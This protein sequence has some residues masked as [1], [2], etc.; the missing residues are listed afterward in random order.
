VRRRQLLVALGGLGAS[1]AAL[2]AWATN[3]GAKLPLEGELAR[4]AVGLAFVLAALLADLQVANSG[5][6]TLMGAVGLT[7]FLWDLSW[8]YLPVPYTVGLAL[9]ALFQP[10]LAHLTVAFPTGRLRSRLD[11][12]LVRVAYSAWM[13]LS[14]AT[15]VVWDPQV[16]CPGGCSANVL[17]LYPDRAL[18]DGLE[19]IGTV[20]GLTITA[21]VVGAVVRHWRTGSPP[22]RRALAP[23]LWSAVPMAG[24]LTAYTL[25]G[26]AQLPPIAPLV[27][28][29][30]PIA[31]LLGL[32]RMRLTRAGV[33]RLVIELG[34]Q[35]P[36]GRLRDALATALRDSALQVVYWNRERCTF[37][38]VDGSAVDLPAPGSHQQATILEGESGPLAA[39]VHDA[40]LQEDPEL[41]RAVA[42]AARLAIENER[43]QAEIRAQ[44]AEV[45]ASRK[46]LVEAGDTARRR[47]ERD[48]HDGSQ[49]H[50]VTLAAQLG[51]AQARLGNHPDPELANLIAEAVA[52][53]HAA[54]AELRQ[55]ARGL[56]PALLSQAGLGPALQA[57]AERSPLPVTIL[58]S[59]PRRLP[60]PVESTAYFV[61][62]ESLANAAKYARATT[63][64]V[65]AEQTDGHVRVEVVD[66]GVGG[67]DARSG[68][69][70]QG[71]ADR[72]GA[73]DGQ[74]EIA[75]PAGGGTRVTAVIP[76]RG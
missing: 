76:C 65:C 63:V 20:V 24:I 33:G 27:L 19:D 62:A 60:S 23:V 70:L 32:V 75:S 46:R 44:L 35:P 15:L 40:A 55:L 69:G 56:H 10:I 9:G 2:A 16:D 53:L 59:P 36:P 37:V 48:L 14:F 5:V 43:L 21:A 47:L 18:H 13:V 71:L 73:L 66:D 64:T 3:P 8:I 72:V 17:L 1:A 67:A 11:R 57:L 39:L 34:E 58:A 7:W 30:L 61:V 31:F 50:L 4:L 52:E 45:R 41:V 49:Q 29:T 22:A 51:L 38:D 26:R 12:N 6:A 42:T 28:L 68:S 25:L 74:F 54:L